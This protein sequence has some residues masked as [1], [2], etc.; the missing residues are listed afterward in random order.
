MLTTKFKSERGKLKTNPDVVAARVKFS[1]KRKLVG[2][3]FHLADESATEA[4][5]CCGMQVILNT[6]YESIFLVSFN[7]LHQVI[8]Q[9]QET[10]ILRHYY[11]IH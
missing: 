8:F 6:N 3:N 2:T 9:Q 4:K 7:S 5:R 10:H 1:A 11:V